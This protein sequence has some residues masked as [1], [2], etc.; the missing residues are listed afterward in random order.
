MMESME[1][2]LAAFGRG[3]ALVLEV[4]GVIAVLAGAVKVVARLL[5]GAVAGAPPRFTALRLDLARFLAL[6]LEFQLAADI[7]G[8]AIS[9]TWD[10]LGRLGAIAVIRTALNY[11]LGVE[12]REEREMLAEEAV[13]DAPVKRPAAR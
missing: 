8:T 2:T 12:M 13:V 6:G 10:Q 7:V 5:R 4:L 11:F 3:A 9:P 1:A